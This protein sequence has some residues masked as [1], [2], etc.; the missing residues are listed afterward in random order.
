MHLTYQFSCMRL[1]ML[2]GDQYFANS[3]NCNSAIVS[4][5]VK[6]VFTK[7]VAIEE[8]I[9]LMPEDEKPKIEG[10]AK[11]NLHLPVFPSASSVQVVD[12]DGKEKLVMKLSDFNIPKQVA[13][14]PKNM[15]GNNICDKAIGEDINNCQADCNIK[16]FNR[17]TINELR[18]IKTQD[19]NGDGIVDWADHQILVNK[20]GQ[21]GENLAEDINNDKR[22]N[23]LD[24]SIV[25]DS[26]D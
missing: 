10:K 19:L 14:T 4:R 8:R 2:V 18:K 24:A 17:D 16:P 1:G 21:S 6:L 25:I 11:L 22:V 9:S 13:V 23:T 26:M 20:Y 12:Q 5:V 3:I 7:Q 15:C